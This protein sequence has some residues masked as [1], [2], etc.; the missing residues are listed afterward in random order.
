M[1]Q[2]FP[3]Q[4]LSLPPEVRTTLARELSIRP[5]GQ[6]QVVAGNGKHTVQSD[7]F[8][9]SDLMQITLAS[10][11]HFTGDTS[12][13]YDHLWQLAV[14]RAKSMSVPETVTTAETKKPVGRPK[15]EIV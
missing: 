14:V 12:S 2:V 9:T 6:R 15:K 7:G 3:R 8:T 4:W 13:D 11:Q 1:S 10:L 5:T